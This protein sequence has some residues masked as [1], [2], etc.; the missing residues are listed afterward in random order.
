MR[1]LLV[2]LFLSLLMATAAE[3]ADL[4][5][6]TE[7]RLEAARA[8]LDGGEVER[9]IASLN[10][11]VEELDGRPAG[12][13]YARELLAQALHSRDRP[14]EAA[15]A[16][17]AALASGQLPEA[18]AQRDRTLLMQLYLAAERPEEA[19][20]AVTLPEPEDPGYQPKQGYLYAWA[21]YR[22]G[23]P[24]GA[25]KTLAQAREQ[26]G[27]DP[28]ADPV[29]ES[30]LRLQ[31][32][33]QRDT[34]QWEGAVRTASQLLGRDHERAD[35]WRS[36]SAIH[37]KRRDHAA[38]IAALNAMEQAD[39]AAEQDRLRLARLFLWRDQPVRAGRLLEQALANGAVASSPENEALLARAWLVAE[40]W[41]AAAQALRRAAPRQPDGQLY[42]QLAR[43]ELDR[44]HPAEAARALEQALAHDLD[45]PGDARILQG[46]ALYY[47][48]RPREALK[49]FEQAVQ[50]ERV[51]AS[52]RSWME[53]VR[54]NLSDSDSPS[55]LVRTP[56]I[57]D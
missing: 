29:P 13:A 4:S 10:E 3:A 57:S 51:A 30:W 16:L 22:H 35:Y 21:E 11:L 56:S 45:S 5:P 25:L 42:L 52:A 55:E 12:Q 50:H 44:Q 47:D 17:E 26:R 19:L 24:E 49:A 6:Y 31:L 7:K 27:A 46:L 41:E 43:L 48:Q 2:L 34:R 40:E 36:L 39:V 15:R 37:L 18:R 54:G 53:Y 1:Y 9:A 38:A 28:D 32:L 23:D 20:R 8:A 14:L 33:L